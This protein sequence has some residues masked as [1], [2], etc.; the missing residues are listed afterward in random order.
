MLTR[1]RREGTAGRRAPVFVALA[2][3]SALVTGLS[4]ATFVGGTGGSATDTTLFGSNVWR[5]PGENRRAAAARIDATYGPIRI[6]RVFSAW[7]PPAWSA[8]ERDL[9]P[10]P[11]VVSFRLPPSMILSGAADDRLAAWFEAAP[12]ERDTFWVYHHEPEDEIERGEFTAEEFV[13]AW[14]RVARLAAAADNPRLR[15]TLVLMCWTVNARSG[16]DW[17]SYVPQSGEVDVLAWDCYA[18]GTDADSYAEP[19]ELLEPARRASRAVGASWAI[20]EVGA[21]TRPG[22]ER[23]RAAWIED[24]A[25]YAVSHDARFVTWFDAPV[26]GNFRLT[27]RPSIRAWASVVRSSALPLDRGGAS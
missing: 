26:G 20:A 2:I 11:V 21:R 17:R 12:V 13:D 6:A 10:R 24:V 7:L 9:G 14:R 27:D 19:I 8:L 1:P 25:G 15:A 5:A 3:L 22:R 18:K 23:D 4:S 16:R